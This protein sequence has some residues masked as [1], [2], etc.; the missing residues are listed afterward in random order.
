MSGDEH[1]RLLTAKLQERESEIAA[2]AKR[3]AEREEYDRLIATI[4]GSWIA[5][6][7]SW[8]IQWQNGEP[9]FILPCANSARWTQLCK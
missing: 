2:I 6:A 5:D 3:T 1:I 4:S 7:E 9:N 8:R